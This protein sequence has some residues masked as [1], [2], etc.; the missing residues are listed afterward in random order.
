MLDNRI[1]LI[2]GGTGKT[3]SKIVKQ[4]LTQNKHIILCTRDPNK[5]RSLFGV[6]FNKI[7]RVYELKDDNS[8]NDIFDK[9]SLI[10][11]RKFNVIS[12]VSYSEDTSS[13]NTEEEFRLNSNLIKLAKQN[14]NVEKFVYLSCIY[15][16]RENSTFS[17]K[18]ETIKPNALYFKS[19]NEFQLKMSGLN[20][21]I[22]RS[23]KLE[24][25]IIQ[26]PMNVTISQGDRAKGIVSYSTLAYV[27]TSLIFSDKANLSVEVA[28]P[29]SEMNKAIDVDRFKS[30]IENLKADVE[31]EGSPQK[32]FI[33]RN[34]RGCYEIYSYNKLAFSLFI[35]GSLFKV[36][37]FYL[38][39]I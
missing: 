5:A 21:L 1:Y 30:E 7:E 20:Y 2:F 25:D 31:I 35:S 15:T 38:R 34:F 27:V 10:N 19:F 23:G 37:S 3:S 24:E 36:L 13:K 16:T 8:L 39:R 32:K 9:I 4:L 29:R 17:F 26:E 12:T 6:D 18:M 14:S 22:I 33:I 28:G 11:N